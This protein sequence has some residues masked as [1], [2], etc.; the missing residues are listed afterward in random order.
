MPTTD[1]ADPSPGGQAG[2]DLRRA[3]AAMAALVPPTVPVAVQ[4]LII[5]ARKRGLLDDDGLQRVGKRAMRR[6]LRSLGEVRAWLAGGKDCTPRLAQSLLELLPESDHIVVGGNRLLSHLADGGMGRVHL[7]ESRDGRMVV[8]KMLRPEFGSNTRYAY[9]FEREAAITAQLDHINLVRCLGHGR[10]DDGQL[11]MVL[12]YVH[13]GDLDCLLAQGHKLSEGEALL[14]AY[15]VCKALEHTHRMHLIHRD[16]KPSNIFLA[17][18]GTAKLADFGLSRATDVEYSMATVEGKAIGS[19]FFMAPEQAQGL[20]DIDIRA[21]LYAIG[22]VLFYALT[23]QPPFPGTP[24]EVLTRHIRDKVPDVRQHRPEI[25][26]RT[27]KTI[28]KLMLKEREQRFQTPGRLG[29]SLAKTMS[30]LGLEP[31]RALAQDTISRSLPSPGQ[32][33]A[34]PAPAHDITT[35]A[36]QTLAPQA[37]AGPL[38]PRPPDLPA[39]PAAVPLP[40]AP[41]PFIPEPALPAPVARLE[42]ATLMP[43]ADVPPA[44]PARALRSDDF[45]PELATDSFTPRGGSRLIGQGRSDE[46]TRDEFDGAEPTPVAPAA[47]AP[48]APTAPVRTATAA[49]ARVPDEAPPRRRTVG[50]NQGAPAAAPAPA[51]PAV[52]AAPPPPAAPP[53]RPPSPLPSRRVVAPLTELAGERDPVEMTLADYAGDLA[54]QTLRNDGAGIPG[55]LDLGQALDA[56]WVLIEAA[57]SYPLRLVLLAQTEAVTG[58]LRE[59]PVDIPL[60]V[61][62]IAAYTEECQRI[63]K[64]HFKVWSDAA[65]AKVFIADLGSSNTTRLD[66]RVLNPDAPW[67]LEDGR[68]HKLEIPKSLRLTVRALPQ[69]T[70][71]E[72]AIAGPPGT[73]GVDSANL[74]DAIILRRSDNRPSLAYALVLR[75][76]TIGS[77]DA[78]IPC[79]GWI[80]PDLEFGQLGGRWTWRLAGANH[81]QPLRARVTLGQTG[82]TASA[83]DYDTYR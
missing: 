52:A 4:A 20:K 42:T 9:R 71:K 37:A 55:R 58:K 48:A 21:D 75:R 74:H 25:G 73:C 26:E 63:S 8:V 78:D 32:G 34:P 22:C 24:V 43:R 39:M 16:I 51:A 81:W 68:E 46:E 13:G 31:E 30:L 83:A 1:R 59:A 64:R 10:N 79:T 82:V 44:P 28:L 60:R 65:S 45:Q 40:P 7:A 66:G 35:P 6:E 11:Y 72:D 36:P 41:A 67:A 19:P 15:Q 77:T 70:R 27:A 23:G 14:V 18:D 76:I 12:E 57:G 47:T 53:A 50:P 5:T 2:R 49:V 62:P 3:S 54:L 29:E 80:G 38:A 17:A 69:R 33:D 56:R 61:Y